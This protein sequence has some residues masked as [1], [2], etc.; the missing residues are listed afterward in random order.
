MKTLATF[1]RT[2][3]AI[4]LDAESVVDMDLTLNTHSWNTEH[5][6]SLWLNNLLDGLVKPENSV[7]PITLS[8]HAT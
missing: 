5:D 2:D 1:V 6:H 3:C 7:P 8:V 4:F